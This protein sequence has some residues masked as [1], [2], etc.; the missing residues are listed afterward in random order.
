M[1]K[2]FVH[3][4]SGT[5]SASVEFEVEAGKVHK[6]AF[7]GGCSGN[8]QGLSALVEGLAVDEAIQRLKGIRCGDSDTSCPDQLALALAEAAGAAPRA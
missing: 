6:V 2:R 1:S 5:C 8:L 7:Q 4:N 3:S